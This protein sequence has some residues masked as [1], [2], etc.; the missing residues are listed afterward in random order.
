M[1]RSGVLA[2]SLLVGFAAAPALAQSEPEVLSS[3]QVALACAPPATLEGAAP[4]AL[5]IIGVQDTHARTT[6][7]PP[8]L[9]VIGG[10]RNAGVQLGQQFF[11][12]RP[13]R[14]G[15]GGTR[16][17]V[18]IRTAG[19][20]RV[21]AVNDTTAIATIEHVCDA[22]YQNDYLAPFAM[23]SMPADADRPETA[24]ELD[25]SSLSRV[26]AG[27]E[28]RRTAGSGDFMLMDHG[29]DQGII[30]GQRFAI[31][32]DV[33]ATG[34]PLAAIGEATVMNVGKDMALV[35]VDRTRAAVYTGDYLV[36]RK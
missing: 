17:P 6:Y 12:R 7:G 23:P 8:D 11:I 26:V 19:W 20:I 29:G 34:V 28:N 31:Y 27:N 18:G 33:G 3:M 22:I 14:F 16:H 13:I 10:G 35:R 1:G 21:A 2:L 4:D 36:P 32:R 30:A 5:R 15:T 9:L 24:G 25:F